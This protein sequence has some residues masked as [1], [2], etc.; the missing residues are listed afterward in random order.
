MFLIG[1]FDSGFDTHNLLLVTINTSASANNPATNTVLLDTT[2]AKLHQVPG[3]SRV[4]YARSAPR[5][6]WSSVG[7]TLPGSSQEARAESTRVGPEYLRLF[8]AALVA[9]LLENRSVQLGETSAKKSSGIEQ[10]CHD[11]VPLF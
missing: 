7:I 1:E 5:E 4:T 3:V 9:E 11:R 2:V 10:R 8:D 6:F